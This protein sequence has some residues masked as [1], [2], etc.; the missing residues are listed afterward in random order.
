[1]VFQP[2]PGKQRRTRVA[3]ACNS[4]S[5]GSDYRLCYVRGTRASSSSS[6]SRATHSNPKRNRAAM[7]RTR[8][9]LHPGGTVSHRLS[10]PAT[11]PRRLVPIAATWDTLPD[12]RQAAVTWR[13]AGRGGP[14][15]VS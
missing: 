7:S 3:D 11:V 4:I 5:L 2:L 14:L 10:R 6:P 13:R 8:N 1:M 15:V 9:L 12:A